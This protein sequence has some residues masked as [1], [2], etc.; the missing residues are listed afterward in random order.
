MLSHNSLALYSITGRSLTKNDGR[1]GLSQ[2][3]IGLGYNQ[4]NYEGCFNICINSPCYS[5]ININ[6]SIL[7]AKIPLCLSTMPFDHGNSATVIFKVNCSAMFKNKLL[8]NSA[9]LSDK[10]MSGAPNTAFQCLIKVSI[11]LSATNETCHS[12]TWYQ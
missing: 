4:S 6:Y 8:L 9:P 12:E 11:V 3:L 2:K 7:F 10:I 1:L 5:S